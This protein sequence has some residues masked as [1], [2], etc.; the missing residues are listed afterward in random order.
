[1]KPEQIRE[2]NV[3]GNLNNQVNQK[4]I[5]GVEKG[6]FYSILNSLFFNDGE[7][8]VGF[9]RSRGVG[10]RF[11]KEVINKPKVKLLEKYKD[12]LATTHSANAP[13]SPLAPADETARTQARALM[14]EPF[15][16]E[17][18][19]VKRIK[20]KDKF[21]WKVDSDNFSAYFTNEKRAFERLD[22]HTSWGNLTVYCKD[23]MLFDGVH[24]FPKYMYFKDLNGVFYQI[25]W[26][27]IKYYS[28][29]EDNS[30]STEKYLEALKKNQETERELFFKPSF[31]L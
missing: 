25:E 10:I 7:M 29:K 21:Y 31:I 23:Y 19:L 16:V 6:L 5:E 15:L 13:G 17:S 28:S 12:F 1:M 11:N 20:E 30:K 9:L 8:I 27:S 14:K 4:G 3:V 2:V 24:E 22:L 26:L 18:P